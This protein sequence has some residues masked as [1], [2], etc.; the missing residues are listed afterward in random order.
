MSEIIVRL[1]ELPIKVNGITI[2]DSNGDYNV[3]I[4]SRLSEDAAKRTC[5]H[6]ITHIMK[7]HHY[8]YRLVWDNELEADNARV[9]LKDI[10]GDIIYG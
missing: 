6:E 1:I 3:Y 9:S 10:M 2:V 5:R 8:D 7:N 4:N